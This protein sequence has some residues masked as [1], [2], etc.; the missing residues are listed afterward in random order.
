MKF[1]YKKFKIVGAAGSESEWIKLFGQRD[2]T[3]RLYI[4]VYRA[5]NR[6]LIHFMHCFVFIQ[7]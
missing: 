6:F 3:L 2:H 7:A 5:E 4:I 1:I